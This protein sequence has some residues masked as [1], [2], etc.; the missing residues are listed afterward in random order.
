MLAD[1]LKKP[2]LEIMNLTTLELDLWA[3]WFK[4]EAEAT[5]G[6]MRKA[7]ANSRRR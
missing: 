2:V 6:Q 4:L 5:N 7:K 1:R 3:A